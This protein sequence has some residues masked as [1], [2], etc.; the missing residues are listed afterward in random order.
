M[1]FAFTEEQ[2]ELRRHARSFLADHCTS[3]NIRQ[4]MQSR[5]GYDLEVWHRITGELG[6][7][8]IL[9]PE[10]HGGIGLGY[11]DLVALL[12]ETGA[13]LLCS[14]LFS[15]VALGVNALIVAASEEQ[16]AIYLPRIAGGELTATLAYTEA[17]G[18]WDARA[19]ECVA[20]RDGAEFVLNGAK[21]FVPDGY[22]AGLLVVAARLPGTQG[23]EGICLF[24]VPSESTGLARTPLPTMDQTRKQAEVR[25][26]NVRVPAT[27]LM[28]EEGA[29]WPALSKMLDL[30]A[31]ALAAEQVGGAQRCLDMSVTYAKERTQFG[32]PIGSFQAIKHKC[33]DMLV[34]V[35]T[36]RSAVYYA[37]WAA[38]QN[39]P[40]LPALASL[41]KAYCSDAYFRCAAEAIQIH[42]GVGFTWEYDLHLYFKRAK[43]TETFL[44]DPPYHRELVAKR[45]GW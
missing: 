13:A 1:R 28:G 8:A 22:T 42:G 39:D 44:G 7:Q 34:L 26:E 17:N 36:A 9:V 16:K 29:A 31:I 15:T 37:A 5:E 3:E 10:S 25:F 19:I 11:V 24:I 12:E 2:L 30:A 27:A 32:R 21:T 35:E 38:S 14:P 41:A 4:V 43:S 23:E 6:W 18:R 40:E 45:L 33:A 20:R